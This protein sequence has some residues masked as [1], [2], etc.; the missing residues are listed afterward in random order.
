MT[1]PSGSLGDI[2]KTA[3][4]WLRFSRSARCTTASGA[5][6]SL[7]AR[8]WRHRSIGLFRP[9]A[10]AAVK[11]ITGGITGNAIRSSI[12]STRHCVSLGSGH[13]HVPRSASV[14]RCSCIR[15]HSSGFYG[16]M[17]TTDPMSGSCWRMERI[18]IRS[19]T[20]W[21]MLS[22]NAGFPSLRDFMTPR[23]WYRWPGTVSFI[24]G[25]RRP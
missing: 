15:K 8:T 25:R 7:L 18:S 24:L 10:R 11:R 23:R 17:S 13:S 1:E 9:R 14:C 6:R 22:T 4:T 21:R 16:P 3:W 19:C 20:T 5:R 12:S 2:V